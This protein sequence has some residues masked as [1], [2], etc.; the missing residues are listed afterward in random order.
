MSKPKSKR[1]GEV[2]LEA[3]AARCLMVRLGTRV[4]SCRG[5]QLIPVV[6]AGA[7]HGYAVVWEGEIVGLRRL[8]TDAVLDA[9]VLAG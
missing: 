5:P 8:Y 1:D 3:G 9:V 6:E 4:G 7:L 2:D